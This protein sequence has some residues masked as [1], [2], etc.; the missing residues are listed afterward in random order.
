MNLFFPPIQALLKAHM[1]TTGFSCF[2]VFPG[3]LSSIHP[4][5]CSHSTQLPDPVLVV[6]PHCLLVS[7][8]W[9]KRLCLT[10]DFNPKCFSGQ[11]PHC[12]TLVG[13]ILVTLSGISTL[14]TGIH[15][16]M[17]QEL[18]K[19]ETG[20][21]QVSKAPKTGRNLFFTGWARPNLPQ[22]WQGSTV[23][24]SP[25]HSI[26]VAFSTSPRVSDLAFQLHSARVLFFQGYH[27]DQKGGG[28]GSNRRN[29][30]AG[31]PPSRGPKPGIGQARTIRKV[32][33]R[34]SDRTAEIDKWR[35]SQSG[36]Q[37]LFSPGHFS[38][39][40]VL[41]SPK[42]IYVVPSQIKSCSFWLLKQTM[43]LEHAVLFLQ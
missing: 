16:P 21:F 26:L 12:L 29:L 6:N 30:G 5:R 41:D 9:S 8:I 18:A 11:Q 14:P 19:L 38:G 36:E 15:S 23:S 20:P 40:W 2:K 39:C 3:V 10:D 7:D 22:V 25:I 42:S 34:I 4:C 17:H 33:A 32:P 28:G 43:L 31:L 35:L 24:Q 27:R 13:P 37:W 1:L